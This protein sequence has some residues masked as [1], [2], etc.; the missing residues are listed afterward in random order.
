MKTLRDS[1]KMHSPTEQAKTLNQAKQQLQLAQTS[2]SP[3]VI[4]PAQRLPRLH[5]TALRPGLGFASDLAGTTPPLDANKPGSAS[6]TAHAEASSQVQARRQKQ[7][8]AEWHMDGGLQRLQDVG[9]V[10][11]FCGPLYVK[12]PKGEELICELKTDSWPAHLARYVF[13]FFKVICHPMYILIRTCDDA[14]HWLRL[15]VI[16]GMRF[17]EN[18]QALNVA[19]AVK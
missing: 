8:T 14:L 16:S 18:E 13:D 3:C 12:G 11:Q 17:S 9:S 6:A 4:T 10:K 1:G 2:S 15:T 19:C 5:P 7:H